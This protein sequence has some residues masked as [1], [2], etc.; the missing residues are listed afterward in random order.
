MLLCLENQASPAAVGAGW[1]WGAQSGLASLHPLKCGSAAERPWRL[2][3]VSG[4][5][6]ASES[7][8]TGE[9]AVGGRLRCGP[10]HLP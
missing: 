4:D 6:S 1:R 10:G 7:E 9:V 8:I 3:R 2:P 5:T